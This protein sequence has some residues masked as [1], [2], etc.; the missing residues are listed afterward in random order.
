[1]KTSII[2]Y[3]LQNIGNENRTQTLLSCIWLDQTFFIAAQESEEHRPPKI[4]S[5]ENDE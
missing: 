2:R 5:G 4:W 1:M 3:C